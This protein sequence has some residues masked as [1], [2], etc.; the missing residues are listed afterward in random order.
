LLPGG[1]ALG[2]G[3]EY[4]TGI[5][6]GALLPGTV[7]V[8]DISGLL[9]PKGQKASLTHKEFVALFSD[10]NYRR[11]GCWSTNTQIPERGDDTDIAEDDITFFLGASGGFS[12][13]EAIPTTD[14]SGKEKFAVDRSVLVLA[15]MDQVSGKKFSHFV[16]AG[17]PYRMFEKGTASCKKANQYTRATAPKTTWDTVERTLLDIWDYAAVDGF[18]PSFHETGLK[19]SVVETVTIANPKSFA[20]EERVWT[21]TLGQFINELAERGYTAIDRFSETSADPDDITKRLFGSD[22]HA[23]WVKHAAPE[24]GYAF[25]RLFLN[26]QGKIER[27]RLHQPSKDEIEHFLQ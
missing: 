1:G 3:I 10:Q 16:I 12:V 11:W 27:V 17:R 19:Q 8:T 15:Y 26:S 4:G 6:E 14:G 13:M 23:I 24:N 22:H 2:R 21:S 7:E 20:F 5:L 9:L 25:L 18:V